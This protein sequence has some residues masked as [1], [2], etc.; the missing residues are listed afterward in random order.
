MNLRTF[1]AT[2]PG[3]IAALVLVAATAGGLTWVAGSNGQAPK[4][5]LRTTTIARGSVTQTV[6]VSGSVSPVGQARM[7]F[8]QP[9][10]LSDVYVTVGQVVTVGQPLAKVETT[11]LENALAQAQTNLDNAQKNLQRQLQSQADAQRA[12]DTAQKQAATD[13]ANAKASLAKIQASYASAKQNYTSQTAGAWADITTFQSSIDTISSQLD[14]AMNDLL[15]SAQPDIK[16]AQSS[17]YL[18]Y[19]PLANI[20]T[21]STTLLAPALAEYQ[22]AR[23]AVV[24]AIIQFDNALASGGDT[25]ATVTALQLAQPTYSLAASRLTAALD[26]TAGP[27]S[28]I[29]G[30]VTSAQT[31]LNTAITKYITVFDA[32]RTDLSNLLV[33]VTTASQTVSTAKLR[34]NQAST[35]LQ[36]LSD[37]IGG[38]YITAMQNVSTTED[39]GQQ[40]IQSAQ[41]ALAGKSFDI[42]SAQNSVTLQ[43]TAVASAQTNLDNAVLRATVAGVVQQVNG[44]VGE[45][46]STSTT[47]PVVLLANTGQVQLHGTIGEAD[48]SKLKLG[49]VA[50]ITIDALTGQKMT[51][52]VSSL[53]PV[54][55]ISQGVPVYGIDIAIDVPAS[56]LKAGM[57]GTAAVILAAKQNVLL[58]PN[59]AI[60]TVSGQRG[61]QVLKGGETIDTRVTFGLANDQFTEAVSGLSEG[62]VVVIPQARATSSG[63]PNRGPG[64]GGQ[65]VIFR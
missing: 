49:Q 30:N 22:T 8:R 60:R 11:D 14:T 20:K 16:N 27:L 43:Q 53:D 2:W 17:L 45:P 37:Q 38:S 46:A 56:S 65:Q 44:N 39:R 50:N 6:S 24:A 42:D 63:Q 32:W 10:R 18:A 34:A 3:R 55:T 12:V 31:S 33:S 13:L 35:S 25:T 59:T 54:A 19:A 29:Q 52:R 64:G 4:T 9:G 57:S 28:G 41:T 51:G 40:S 48:V 21:Y 15:T 61:V 36:T 47:T 7:S 1:V 62:D 23:G 58:V 26:A 5:E